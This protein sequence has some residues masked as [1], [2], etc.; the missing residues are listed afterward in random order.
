MSVSS[1]GVPKRQ[2]KFA[3]NL[4][5]AYFEAE[6]STLKVL[7]EL[8]AETR[9]LSSAEVAAVEE[10]ARDAGRLLH[11][12]QRSTNMAIE[13]MSQLN[14]ELDALEAE[15]KRLEN[16]LAHRSDALTAAFEENSYINDIGMQLQLLLKSGH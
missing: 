15:K 14:N 4:H 16:I 8:D 5:R 2:R 7:D 9:G 11:R 13:T 3:A 6:E 10:V 1:S 12:W